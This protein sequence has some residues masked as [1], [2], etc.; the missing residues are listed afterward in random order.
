MPIP[1]GLIFNASGVTVIFY[2]RSTTYDERYP[3]CDQQGNALKTGSIWL[4]CDTGAVKRWTKTPFSEFSGFWSSGQIYGDTDNGTKPAESEFRLE[5]ISSTASA[6]I[7][8]LSFHNKNGLIYDI[9]ANDG[10]LHIRRNNVPVPDDVIVCDENGK[11]EINHQLQVNGTIVQSV[12][13]VDMSG[14]IPNDVSTVLVSGTSNE[15]FAYLQPGTFIGQELEILRT[16]QTPVYFPPQDNSFYSRLDGTVKGVI[17]V[18]A[19]RFIVYGQFANGVQTSTGAYVPNTSHCVLFNPTNNTFTSM[20]PG[21]VVQNNDGWNRV[22]LIPGTA[23]YLFIGT[24]VTGVDTL[25]Q[26]RNVARWNSVTGVWDVPRV[27]YGMGT[28]FL[29]L[30]DIA[31]RSVWDV[32]FDTVN[33][34]WYFVGNFTV[35]SASGLVPINANFIVRYNPTAQSIHLVGGAGPTATGLTGTAARALTWITEGIDFIVGGNFTN[36]LP[37]VSTQIGNLCRHEI[38]TNTFTVLPNAGPSGPCTATVQDV[39]YEPSESKLYFVGSFL[40][41]SDNAGGLRNAFRTGVY[42][43]ITNSFSLWGVGVGSGTVFSI[44]HIGTQKGIIF[45][46]SNRLLAQSGWLAITGNPPS[47]VGESL[48]TTSRAACI[49]IYNPNTDRFVGIHAG[50]P[51]NAA[52]GQD[53][54]DIGYDNG[55]IYVSVGTGANYSMASVNTSG[56]V[57]VIGPVS[58]PMR[59]GTGIDLSIAAGGSGFSTIMVQN[60]NNG[61]GPSRNE[62]SCFLMSNIA[63]SLKLMWT[64]SFW[65]VR[66]Y[67]GGAWQF[68]TPPTSGW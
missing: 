2:A 59:V 18:D 36:S 15:R 30:G 61:V 51:S 32:L 35:V 52:T 21:G 1:L 53:Q 55:R 44:V 63:D 67:N 50:F 3:V 47:S 28:E 24:N 29:W 31:T 10:D 57:Y 17:K 9:L 56:Q 45:A 48:G 65:A 40:Q 13:T 12:G 62:P 64:G 68:S 7:P 16:T 27:N 34:Q 49:A 43:F 41:I 19:T 37:N 23:S 33:N 11:V 39:H 54:H 4:D 8:K 6:A 60:G 25:L 5:D 42:D 66:N 58:A 22:K 14:D 26:T 20:T 38:S 46:Q